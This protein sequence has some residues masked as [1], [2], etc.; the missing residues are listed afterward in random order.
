M[1]ILSYLNK[2]MGLVY[3]QP[4]NRGPEAGFYIPYAW[5]KELVC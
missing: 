5:V 2:H 1:G 4:Q 3:A